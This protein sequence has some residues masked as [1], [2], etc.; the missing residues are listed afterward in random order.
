MAAGGMY[1]HLGGGFARYSV[2][3]EWLVPHFEKMLYD[4]ALLA[5]IYLHAW[6]V[7]GEPR[8]RQVLDEVVT[9]VL[10]DLR[11]QDRRLSQRRGRR[12]SGRRRAQPRG[13]VLRVDRWRDRRA[14]LG[15]ELAEEAKAW[16]GVT[17][18][19]NF[20]GA[21]IL[22]RPVRGDLAPPARD[23]RGPPPVVRGPR[24]APPPRARRQG[25]RPSGTACSSPRWPRRR[26]RPG[27]ASWLEGR[28]AAASSCWPTSAATTVVGSARGRPTAAPA[29]SPWPPTTPRSWLPSS[30]SPRRPGEPAGSPRPAPW[31][32][33]CST[34]SGTRC[35]A[36]SSR[37]ARTPRSWWRAR[38][39]CSTTPRRRPT[40]RPPSACYRLGA[41]TGEAR[42]TNHA[43]QILRLARPAHHPVGPAPSRNV[44]AAVD[45]RRAG[46]TEIAVVG[47]RPELVGPPSSSGSCRT[48]CWPGAS[49][50]TPRSGSTALTVSPTCAVTTPAR[51]RSRRSRGRCVTQL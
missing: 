2:D 14:V 11:H 8:Y 36:P 21:T 10:R 25:A 44:L 49:P 45:L 3:D 13:R 19:G 40:P 12:L 27:S 4:Q 38:R 26:R 6:Q 48:P 23:R 15:P 1:D 32:T 7:T 16:W 39:T 18:A 43:D 35:R 41:L 31:P 42:Y 33:P 5:R 28:G 22:H 37:P 17:E 46:I 29:T 30:P 51:P 24:A 47:D 50:T 20:E 9:Y 34:C